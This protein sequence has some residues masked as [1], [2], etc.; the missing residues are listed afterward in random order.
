MSM[1]DVRGLTFSYEGSLENVFE[2]VSFRIDSDWKLGFVGRNGRGK[3]TFLKLLMGEYEYSGRIIS[4]IGFEYFPFDVSEPE[5]LVCDIAG[6]ICPQAQQWELIRELSLLDMDGGILYRQFSTL[7]GGERTK[8]LLAMLFLKDDTFLLIDEPTNHLDANGRRA[9]SRYLKSKKRFILVSHDRAVLDECVDH[10]LSIN[11]TNIEIESGNYSSWE[12]NKQAR[13]NFEQVQNERLKREIKQLEAAS[14]RAAEH[15]Q[16]IESTKI[17]FDPRKT[18][19]STSRRSSIAAKSKKLMNRS[20]A[21]E[22]RMQRSADEKRGLMKNIET[23]SALKL[24]AQEYHSNTL[25][26]L[27]GVS[28]SYGGRKICEPVDLTLHR[29]ERVVLEG[30]N[31][32]GKSSLIK[33]IM[34][35]PIENTGLVN[36]GSQLKIS[37]VS[38]DSSFLSG[39]LSDYAADM[40]IDE[41]LFKAI[42]RK[43]DF[44]REQFELDISEFSEGQ[45]KKTMIAASLCEKAHLY[46][47]DEPLNYIDIYS[48]VQIERLICEFS[49]AMIL[50]EHDETFRSAVNAK[51][52]NIVPCRGV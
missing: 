41:S 17:G 35:Q 24:S 19:K 48:R 5:M 2:E 50:V 27:T 51:T 37:Y 26:S 39:S 34:G 33:L 43:M 42:L 9:V 7:S 29:G 23:S 30:C 14:R 46:I 6:Q 22:T 15:S 40:G 11:K 52:V 8:V 3:T 21:I 16:R 25:L 47:W 4:G 28:V 20:K 36:I 13:D 31:G 10:V 44:S 32:S 38:Q 12:K 1:I 18:E 45:K 49:P